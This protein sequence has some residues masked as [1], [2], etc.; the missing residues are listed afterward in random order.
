MC[1][2]YL[3]GLHTNEIENKS[4]PVKN[5]IS[6]LHENTWK[7]SEVFYFFSHS[8]MF[9][10]TF[11]CNTIEGATE[12]GKPC[13][14]PY[15]D[16]SDGRGLQN[17]CTQPLNYCYTRTDENNI[18]FTSGSLKSEYWGYCRDDCR[19]EMPGRPVTHFRNLLP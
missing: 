4:L 18:I 14:F 19:G 7:R 9:N 2:K 5:K 12:E 10:S 15:I 11:P 6:I 1:K 17:N 8:K 13:S 16:L 3:N